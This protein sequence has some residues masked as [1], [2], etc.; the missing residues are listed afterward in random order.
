M[1][2]SHLR[3]SSCQR[4]HVY[5]SA[6]GIAACMPR[7]YR[8]S[9]STRRF[10]PGICTTTR[11]SYAFGVIKTVCRTICHGPFCL[12]VALILGHSDGGRDCTSRC[13]LKSARKANLV[14]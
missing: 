1:E 12:D 3:P 8:S 7:C 11:A 13:G 2:A 6:G 9:W 14:R 4:V 5:R 10:N